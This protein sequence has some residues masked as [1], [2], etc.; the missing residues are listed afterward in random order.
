MA[1]NHSKSSS[2]LFKIS[3][4]VAVLCGIIMIYSL[5]GV[6]QGCSNYQ[7]AKEIK[8][9]Y[10]INLPFMDALKNFM[11][12]RGRMNVVLSDEDPITEANRSFITERRR[13]SDKSF[14]TGFSEMEKKYPEE[15]E[16]LR[17]EFDKI[18][19][20][21]ITVDEEAQKSIQQREPTSRTIWYKKGNRYRS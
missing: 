16:L 21:R 9:I 11:F 6:Y 10:E 2:I 13:A 15:A 5:S 20:L 8:A 3:I 7:Q 19:K 14:E 1:A 4:I 18:K 17:E 12:E